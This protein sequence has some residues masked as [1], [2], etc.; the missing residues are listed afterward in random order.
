MTVATVPPLEPL[1]GGAVD[2]GVAMMLSLGSKLSSLT[3]ITVGYITKLSAN[4]L[5]EC[6]SPIEKRKQKTN[7]EKCHTVPL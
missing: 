1:D 2:F 5:K 7:T 3:G 6:L 4:T